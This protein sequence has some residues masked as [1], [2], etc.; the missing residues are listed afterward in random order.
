MKKTV[1]WYSYAL[2]ASKSAKTWILL[3]IYWTYRNNENFIERLI[4]VWFHSHNKKWM[5]KSLIT[6]MWRG[7]KA[8]IVALKYINLQWELFNYHFYK[9]ITVFDKKKILI[10]SPVLHVKDALSCELIC[11]VIF[12]MNNQILKLLK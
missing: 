8:F 7:N 11:T 12:S 3:K 1:K 6:V 10:I 2:M 9:K 4:R 5:C